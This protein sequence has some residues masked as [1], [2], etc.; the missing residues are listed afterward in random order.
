MSGIS[1]LKAQ[2]RKVFNIN[3]TLIVI[4]P[5]VDIWMIFLYARESSL[6]DGI[7]FPLQEVLFWAIIR[8]SVGPILNCYAFI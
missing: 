1:C 5:L 3:I 6:C 7:C 4:R 8:S 2:Q